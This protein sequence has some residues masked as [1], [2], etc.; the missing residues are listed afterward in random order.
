MECTHTDQIREVEPSAQGYEECLKSGDT[1][2]HLRMCLTCGHVGC[3][4]LSKNSMRPNTFMRP[5]ILSCSHLRK[6][7]TGGG[8]LWMLCTFEHQAFFG[9][10][11]GVT[12][13]NGCAH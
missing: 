1:W 8:A 4:D 9:I 12:S 7:R 13:D 6:V 11:H 3:C 10:M 2:V 5:T